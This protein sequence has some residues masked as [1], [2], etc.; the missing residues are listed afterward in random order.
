MFPTIDHLS[1]FSPH[2]ASTSAAFR[3]RVMARATHPPRLSP[4]APRNHERLRLAP[5]H[6]AALVVT[7]GSRA[8]SPPTSSRRHLSPPQD[9]THNMTHYALKDHQSG[10]QLF[11][12]GPPH[13]AYMIPETETIFVSKGW[14][15]YK[16]SDMAIQTQLADVI[17]V[18]YALH[19]FVRRRPMSLPRPQLVWRGHHTTSQAVSL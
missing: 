16:E 9:L 7:N 5:R 15:K 19:Y 13:S 8:D 14:H 12:G 4:F 6:A 2:L 10:G 1:P 11:L 18:N 3:Q 17:V